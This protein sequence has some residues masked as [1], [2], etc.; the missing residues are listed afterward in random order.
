V[1]CTANSIAETIIGL[2]PE[3]PRLGIAAASRRFMTN[4]WNDEF[5]AHQF[6][7]FFSNA[8]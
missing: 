8:V 2:L 1:D 5:L 4:V 7:N 6:D 3:T